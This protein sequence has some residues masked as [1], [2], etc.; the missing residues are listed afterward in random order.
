MI[1]KIIQSKMGQL[2]EQ[3]KKKYEGEKVNVAKILANA[4]KK[5]DEQEEKSIKELEKIKMDIEKRV[6][7]IDVYILSIRVCVCV[8][9]LVVCVPY[10][11]FLLIRTR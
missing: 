6:N 1:R 5:E 11:S 2:K 7:S 3:M 9:I 8:C 10:N 4:R